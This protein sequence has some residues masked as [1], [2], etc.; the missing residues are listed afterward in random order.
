MDTTSTPP[1][2]SKRPTVRELEC[3]APERFDLREL[4]TGSW[5]SDT[6]R[7]SAPSLVF[8]LFVIVPAWT[9]LSWVRALTATVLC[10]LFGVLFAFAGAVRRYGL[11]ATAGWLGMMWLVLALLALVIHGDI[12]YLVMFV[13]MGHA[14]ALPWVW[15]RVAVLV[16]G[17]AGLAYGIATENT[18]VVVLDLAG[19][20]LGLG[21]AASIHKGI[22]EDALEAVQRR[23][24]VLAVS[25]ERERIGR[26]L[27]DILGHSLTTI[28]VS[29]QLAKRLV[30]IDP[31]AARAQIQEIE[32]IARQSL[33]DVRATASVMQQ[34]RAAAE[35]ASAR[36]VLTAAGIE[37]ATPVSLPVLHDA[38]AELLGYVVREGVTNVVRHSQATRCRIDLDPHGVS[39]EDD[40]VGIAHGA[41]R[42]GLDGLRRRVEEAGGTL[43]VGSGH[44]GWTLLDARLSTDTDDGGRR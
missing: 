11:R 38:D 3:S 9:E 35:I 18:V 40:G 24:A 8:L 6:V 33:A 14:I 37:P 10:L 34:V 42:T 43:T 44:D 7:Y 4:L 28:T 2:T 25:A 41:A 31:D 16:I 30:D 29:A 36:S 32:R 20:A 17:L 13:L 26:D 5:R 23:N 1:A 12:A 39:I 21:I 19:V 27:H 22:L 15:G